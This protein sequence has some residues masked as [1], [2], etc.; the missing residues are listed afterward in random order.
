M[1]PLADPAL[2]F[3]QQSAAPAA[4]PSLFGSNVIFFALLL[5]GMYFLLFAPQRKKQKEQAKM[6]A[7]LESGD[8][9]LTS[10][11]IFGTITNIKDDRFVV[12]IGEDT[13]VEILKG[14]VQSVVSKKNGSE[15]KK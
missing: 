3:A 15:E 12:R 14:F 13:K 4:A 10:S 5:A 9:I 8:E 11:G 2:F 1:H 6:L 7:A